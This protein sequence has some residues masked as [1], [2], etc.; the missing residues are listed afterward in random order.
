MF[1]RA[2]VGGAAGGF[3]P[4]A[5]AGFG[6][7]SDLFDAFF[8]GGAAGG[9]RRGRPAVGS[10]LRYDL[11]ITFEESIRGTEKEIEFP[12]LDRCATCS[13]LRG[14][15]R[16]GRPDLSAVQRPRRDPSCAPDDARPDGQRRHV[17]ALPRRRQDRRDAVRRLQRRRPQAAH[18]AAPD[19]GPGRDRRRPPDPPLRRGRGG[20]ARRPAGQPLRRDPR[21]GPPAAPTRGDRAVPR[22][23]PV[24]RPGRARDDGP[25][26]TADGE[27]DLEIKPGTQPGH[28]DPAARPRRART[29]AG[30]APAATST[31]SSTCGSR[32]SS[33]REQREALEAY[34]AA[35]G[36]TN[37]G[38]GKAGVLDRIKDVLGDGAEPVE[39][40]RSGRRRVTAGSDPAADGLV[41][42]DAWL[43]LAVTCDP[44][45]VEAVSEILSR[46]APG[47][48]ERGARVHAGRRGARG[49]RRPGA[50]RRPCAPTCPARDAAAAR[51]ARRDEVDRALGHLQAF[52][53]REIG[54]LRDPRRPR[55]GLGDR[56]E[57]PRRR[58]A[59]RA[60]DRHP[61]DLAPPPPAARRRRDRHGP[62]HGVRDRPPP[63]D[64]ALPG[65]HR[66]LGRRGAPGPRRRPRRSGAAARR[67][68]RLRDP[69]DRGGAPGRRRAGRRGHGPDRRRGDA[70]QRPP[71]PR[72]SSA[73]RPARLAAVGRRALRPRGREPHRVGAR[74]P[75]RRPR[76]GAGAGRPAARVGHLR[77]PRGGRPRRASRRPACAW[78]G[79]TPRATGWRSTRSDPP[80]G[81]PEGPAVLRRAG[82]SALLRYDLGP[83]TD[84]PF[85]RRSHP[86]PG[87]PNAEPRSA[88][89]VHPGRST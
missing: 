44:E 60:A 78:S 41:G 52:G 20:A 53:L 30:P 64:A 12:V 81:T 75:R 84:P 49:G 87:L 32:R 2:G 67:G 11:R 16:D 7:F 61:A 19:R 56:L 18:E 62:G 79:A 45:A 77:R 10:D 29:C 24:D 6:A 54:E 28:G 47:G 35:S 3:D 37:V 76:G 65:R 46:V 88:L 31:C 86:R 82:R 15:G 85:S 70:R 72:R 33:T 66:A 55:V 42:D 57:A 48:V 43:E 71:Q 83:S 39:D 59:D 25:V 1:G 23:R 14:E 89:P 9:V 27:E 5:G 58:A 17:P 22:A 40:A 4:A 74:R 21:R 68:L 63:D 69:R 38:G 26:P 36:E 51:T 34:A 50:R 8:G 80:S 73:A 13:G